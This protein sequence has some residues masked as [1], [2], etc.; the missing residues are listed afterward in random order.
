MS[1]SGGKSSTFILLLHAFVYRGRT[2]LPTLQTLKTCV[3]PVFGKKT[4][5]KIDS[6]DVLLAIGPMWNEILSKPDP[7][8]VTS[9][10][11]CGIHFAI[12]RNHS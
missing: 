10:R 11:T 8:P 4:V 1:E 2:F 12:S 5:D 6:V 7:R 9:L 3:F